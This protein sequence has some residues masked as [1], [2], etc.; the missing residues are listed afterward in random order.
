MS[1]NKEII[2]VRNLNNHSIEEI[3]NKQNSVLP[4]SDIYENTDEYIL[5]ANM[6]GVARNDIQVKIVDESLIIFGKIKY[7][8]VMSREYILNENELGN[9]FRKFRISDTID[10]T[11]ISAKYDDGQLVVMLPKHEKVKPRK[12]DIL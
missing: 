6:P 4:S 3:L 5:T 2:A 1:E 7:D 12:I 10:K 11:K 9:Y 8:E